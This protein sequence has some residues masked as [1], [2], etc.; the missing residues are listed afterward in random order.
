MGGKEREI[1]EK[2]KCIGI[3]RETYRGANKGRGE[4][5]E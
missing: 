1:K 4:W 2:E 3:G 5:K